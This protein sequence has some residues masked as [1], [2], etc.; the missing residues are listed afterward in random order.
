[1]DALLSRL[2]YQAVNYALRSG[3]ALTSSYAIHQ[4]SRLVKEVDDSITRAELASLREQL[5]VRIK[6][7]RINIFLRRPTY[8]D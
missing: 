8:A 5:D 7:S 6:V 3:I 1:M 2:G 4:F